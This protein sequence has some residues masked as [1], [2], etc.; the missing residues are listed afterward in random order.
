MTTPSHPALASNSPEAVEAFVSLWQNHAP[1]DLIANLTTKVQRLDIGGQSFPLTLNDGAPTC[2]LCHPTTGYIDYAL[3]ETRNFAAHPSLRAA[4]SALIRVAKPLVKA[5]GLDRQVQLNNWLFST[6]P[7]PDLTEAQA[8][9]IRDRLLSDHPTRAI[10]IRSLN[11]MADAET[12]EALTSAGFQL[13][14][15]RQIYIFSDLSPDRRET[16]NM[17]RDRKHLAK[18]PLTRIGN[19]GFTESDYLDCARL[20]AAL[21]L[22]KYTALNPDYTAEYI[23]QMHRAGLIQLAGFRDE[24]GALVAVTGL[25]ESG[26]TLTQPI[27]GYDTSR[28]MA[29]GLYRLVM[30]VARDHAAAKGLFFNCSAGAAGFKRHR[31]GVSVIEYTAVYTRHLPRHRRFAG[32]L[33]RGILTKVGIPLLERFRL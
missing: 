11:K 20:Y 22:H 10:L 6:N 23:A 16:T 8:T 2:Y 25:F 30:Q 7:V 13:L 26:R 1:E 14:P 28:P 18:T 31:G 24:T 17:R 32:A 12:M 29:E 15:A 33:M 3:D 9:E 5:A 27:V 21:Y 19:D 4:T